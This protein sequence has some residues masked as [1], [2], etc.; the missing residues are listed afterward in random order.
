MKLP[1][2]V[3]GPVSEYI[4]R[5]EQHIK[6]LN[7]GLTIAHRSLLDADGKVAEVREQLAEREAP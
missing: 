4:A 5:L 1:R 3:W 2:L 6:D 7:I